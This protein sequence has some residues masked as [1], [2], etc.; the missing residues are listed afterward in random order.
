VPADTVMT[1]R[2]VDWHPTCTGWPLPKP[3][4]RRSR[5]RSTTPLMGRPVPTKFNGRPFPGGG[6]KKNII[7]EGD[8]L[9]AHIVCT[10]VVAVYGPFDE[11]SR[12]PLVYDSIPLM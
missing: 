3:R 6:G 10:E 4:T 12:F 5:R 11:V 9:R 7:S 1:C 8:S 2:L